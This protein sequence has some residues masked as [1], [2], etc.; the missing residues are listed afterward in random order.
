MLYRAVLEVLV[1]KQARFALA[2]RPAEI[3]SPWRL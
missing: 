1:A 2:M 3:M